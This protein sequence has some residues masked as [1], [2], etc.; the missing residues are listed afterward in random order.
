MQGT[1]INSKVVKGAGIREKNSDIYI[2]F[3]SISTCVNE[4]IPLLP[5]GVALWQ[6]VLLQD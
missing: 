5:R 1:V 2:Y 6:L 4:N 3:I